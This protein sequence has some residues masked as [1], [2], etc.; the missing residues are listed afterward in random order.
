MHDSNQ[1]HLLRD[2]VQHALQEVPE[3]LA[4]AVVDTQMGILLA[5]ATSVTIADEIIDMMSMALAR[6]LRGRAVV[7]IERALGATHYGDAENRNHFFEE[8][9]L[10]SRN[11]LHMIQ[12]LDADE[13]LFFVTVVPN[14]VPIGM[15]LIKTHSARDSINELLRNP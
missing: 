3:C 5:H 1:T 8:L 12:R 11:N 6:Q 13:D 7:N 15:V 10:F 4:A 9:I 2:A 14:T